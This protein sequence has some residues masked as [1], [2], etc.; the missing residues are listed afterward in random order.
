ML[1]QSL[2]VG[3]LPYIGPP[4]HL[5][6]PSVESV[7]LQSGMSEVDFRWILDSLLHDGIIQPVEA[8]SMDAALNALSLSDL[9]ELEKVGFVPDENSSES[10]VVSLLT[11]MM[12]V[13]VGCEKSLQS[14]EVKSC[15]DS[16]T[17]DQLS[18]AGIWS[19]Q[20]AFIHGAEEGASPITKAQ[21]EAGTVPIN[22]TVLHTY[23]EG[24]QAE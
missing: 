15:L 8:V 12:P 11:A 4:F 24:M 18:Q 3:F 1:L 20:N 9:E 13:R 19:L 7:L 14:A 21:I 17:D 16:Y 10:M 2:L 22:P 5:Q 23:I 6:T